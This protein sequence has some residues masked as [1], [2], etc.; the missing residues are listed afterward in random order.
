MN[1]EKLKQLH[2]EYLRI[3]RINLAANPDAYAWAKPMTVAGNTGNTVFAAKTPE[4]MAEKVIASVR[5][6]RFVVDA[7]AAPTLNKAVRN[8]GLKPT[9][10]ALLEWLNAA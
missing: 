6:N 4:E 3:L 1:A 7:K 5:E 9:Q 2:A 10:K 8:L